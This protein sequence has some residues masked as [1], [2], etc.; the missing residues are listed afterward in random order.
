MGVGRRI[1]SRGKNT[2]NGGSNACTRYADLAMIQ[3]RR[4]RMRAQSQFHQ[5]FGF[6]QTR[7]REPVH[8]LVAQHGF[9]G[10][11]IPVARGIALEVA[12]TNQ[13]LLNLLHALRGQ[14]KARQTLLAAESSWVRSS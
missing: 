3:F 12:I 10:A 9:T 8:R 1:R 7:G 14:M 4:Q 13:R 5:R 11:G 6:G 2:L